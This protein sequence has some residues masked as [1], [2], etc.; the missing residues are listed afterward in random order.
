M[1]RE[2]E[3]LP[4]CEFFVKV[5]LSSI[6][7]SN[8]I[9]GLGS[10]KEFLTFITSW[11]INSFEQDIYLSEDEAWYWIKTYYSSIISFHNTIHE[12]TRDT[13]FFPDLMLEIPA[14]DSWSKINLNKSRIEFDYP[15]K[16]EIS[17]AIAD[18]WK[19]MANKEKTLP[20][21]EQVNTY[22][23]SNIEKFIN[24]MDKINFFGPKLF[25]LPIPLDS[26]VNIR[27][28]DYSNPYSFY[29]FYSTVC[30]DAIRTNPL[31]LK[32][33]WKQLRADLV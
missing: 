3:F 15:A 5:K 18:C 4:N 24:K 16:P 23:Q 22:I 30:E 17:W 19:R 9:F 20:F 13:L 32:S 28:I 8:Q 2:K 26:N 12:H 27:N 33:L 7:N 21:E 10:G 31:Y 29:Y 11:M 1:V 6:K 25:N 14:R